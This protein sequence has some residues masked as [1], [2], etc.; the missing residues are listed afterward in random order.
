MQAT[1]NTPVQSQQ[2]G[3]FWQ[4]AMF[5]DVAMM[6]LIITNLCLI[7]FDWLYGSASFERLISQY[8]PTFSSTYA[9]NIHANFAD[10]DL[11]FVSIYLF[12]FTLQ[13]LIAIAKKRYYRWFFYPFIHWY[14]LL[15]CIPVGSFRWLRILRIFSI[16]VRLQQ[17]G[18][19]D[20]RQT[21]LGKSALKYYHIVIEEVSDRVVINVLDGAQEEITL[22]SPLLEKVQQEVFSPRK[23]ALLELISVRLTSGISQAHQQHRDQLEEYLGH[24][25]D[26]VLAHSAAG[27]QLSALPFASRLLRQQIRSFG[28]ALADSVTED[29]TSPNGITKISELIDSA[30]QQDEGEP[31]TPLIQSIVFDVIEQIKAQVA[32]QQWKLDKTAD[33]SPP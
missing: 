9:T 15:G 3:R 13:W 17:L 19:I 8:L 30:I 25:T 24:I 31:L 22:G 23:Q 32:I 20:L 14:D 6:L 33:Q 18:W 27:R 7:I 5:V 4:L 28:L 26:E 11:I 12:E 21:Y 2:H 1:D 29:L 16:L 10:I